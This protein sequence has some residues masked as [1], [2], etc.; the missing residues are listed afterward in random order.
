MADTAAPETQNQLLDNVTG[1]L[2]SKSE[3]KRRQKQRQKDA[4]K[5][6]KAEKAAANAPARP[7]NDAAAEDLSLIH[8]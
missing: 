2:V 7:A 4:E 5:A 1:E 3:L 6:E 8:I